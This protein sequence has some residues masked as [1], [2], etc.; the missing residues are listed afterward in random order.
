M[1]PLDDVN[2]SAG[3]FQPAQMVEVVPKAKVGKIFGFTV[4]VNVDGKAQ[5]PAVGVNVYTPPF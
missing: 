5:S 3:T 2:G 1:I 4:T